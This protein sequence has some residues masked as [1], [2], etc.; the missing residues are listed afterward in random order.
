[1]GPEELEIH[2]LGK[3]VGESTVVGLPNYGW[4][5]IDSF[6]DKQT[7]QPA[8]LDL[9]DELQINYTDVKSI[10]VTHWHNDHIRGVSRIAEA[11]SNAD[12]YISAAMTTKPFLELAASYQ[13]AQKF[14]RDDFDGGI[15]EAA[16]L[17]ELVRKG[18][19]KLKQL[20]QD[21]RIHTSSC[22]FEIWSL[23]PPQATCVQCAAYFSSILSKN[24]YSQIA[25]V[26]NENFHSVVLLIITP[27]GS[28]LLGG[29]LEVHSSS[30]DHGWEAVVQSD[31][32]PTCAADVF[33]IPHHGSETGHHEGVWTSMVAPTS[34]SIVTEFTPSSLP[35]KSDVNRIKGK[36]K[37]L[38]QTSKVNLT[39]HLKKREKSVQN[40]LSAAAKKQIGLEGKTGMVSIKHDGSVF[41]AVEVKAPAFKY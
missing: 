17:F 28:L 25:P 22:G 38:Y 37:D 3:G 6:I 8:A 14:S 32:R 10:L 34:I 20:T 19:R 36:T 40:T 18:Q 24:K 26:S 35:A 31:G 1:M 12:I 5:I 30:E 11:C 29:D 16:Q 15:D 21:Q 9:L 39:K 2:I 33:K 4:L 23:S 27:L 41:T 13:K 7:K